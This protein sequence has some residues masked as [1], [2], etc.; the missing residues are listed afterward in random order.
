MCGDILWLVDH[1]G[2]VIAHIPY[3]LLPVVLATNPATSALHGGSRCIIDLGGL[4]I[5]YYRYVGKIRKKVYC[6]FFQ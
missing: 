5:S 3:D 2:L 6:L 4:V 1:G